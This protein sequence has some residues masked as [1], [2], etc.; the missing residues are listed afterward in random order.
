MKTRVT[1]SHQLSHS[2]PLSFSL[3]FSLSL[4]LHASYSVSHWSPPADIFTPRDSLSFILSLYECLSVCVYVCVPSQIEQVKMDRMLL[5][6]SPIHRESV[7]VP[8]PVSS[9]SECE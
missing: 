5:A 9:K 6:F 1:S 3:V 2:F 8:H 4:S 7:G